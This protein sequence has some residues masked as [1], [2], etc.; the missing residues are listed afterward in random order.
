MDKEINITLDVQKPLNPQSAFRIFRGDNVKFN[1]TFKNGDTALDTTSAVKSQVFAKKIYA[2]GV[3][4]TDLPIFSGEFTTITTATFTSLQTAGDAGNYLMAVMLLDANDEL[5]T[6]QAVHLNVVENGYAGVYQ[7]SPDFRDDVLD[8]LAQ[9]QAEAVKAAKSA[10]AAQ[11]AADGA[12]DSKLAAAESASTANNSKVAAASSASSAS[13]YAE[14][15][16]TYAENASTYAENASTYAA[17]AEG[18]SSG[19]QA[20]AQLAATSAQTAQQAAA[21]ATEIS[22]PEG[23]RTN[24][25]AMISDLAASKVNIGTFQFGAAGGALQTTGNPMYGV[26][27]QSHCIT[28]ELDEDW[29]IPTS[30]AASLN[31]FGD[32]FYESGYCGIGAT[33]STTGRIA[34]RVGDG[35]SNGGA[36]QY[37]P[38]LWQI[39]GGS[40]E[41]IIPAG[42][43]AVCFCIHF[44][45]ITQNSDGNYLNPSTCKIYTNGVYKCSCGQLKHKVDDAWVVF[46][47]S[48]VV[49]SQNSKLGFFDTTNFHKT[50]K[51]S[52]N[53]GHYEGKANR[54]AVFNFDMS[55]A[56]APYTPSDYASGKKIPLA[57]CSST[58]EKR[59]ILATADYTFGGKV[60]DI[61]GNENHLTV[62]GD[63]KGDKDEAVRQM[64]N[65]FSA[66]YTD[67]HPTT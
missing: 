21:Q 36:F 45:D 48:E 11:S 42:K 2:D 7:P 52:F 58:A 47:A 67:E 31:M 3:H 28:F 54:F 25:R 51:T 66:A 41:M 15:A 9:A 39:F 55:A 50:D 30:V 5:I 29:S 56:D 35:S 17:A 65:A 33:F 61:S 24:T 27:D 19:A 16:S 10:T 40:N 57:L 12:N 59:C 1:F 20:Q 6:V 46:G 32:N 8:A 34:V 62:C 38:L 13:T 18:Y 63:V 22:D 64:Y 23:W 26:L 4:K 44:G 14:N 37:I 53:Y 43:Y 49:W 60:R